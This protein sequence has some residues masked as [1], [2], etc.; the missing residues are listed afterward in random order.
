MW[1]YIIP[2]LFKLYCQF[3]ALANKIHWV[4][5]YNSLFENIVLRKPKNIPTQFNGFDC[6]LYSI[7]YMVSQKKYFSFFFATS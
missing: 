5:K 4:F 3:G 7:K 2:N 6:E 1:L